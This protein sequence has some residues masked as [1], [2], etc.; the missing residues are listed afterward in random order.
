M[1]KVLPLPSTDW[2]VELNSEEQPFLF[3]TKSQA[4]A[5]AIAWADYHQPCEVRVFDATGELQR[6]ITLPSGDYRRT[7]APDRRHTE[8]DIP[9]PNRRQQERRG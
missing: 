5:F 8:V 1:V 2:R 3:P 7:T 9:F 4:I 6:D